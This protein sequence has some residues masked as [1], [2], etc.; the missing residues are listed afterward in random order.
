MRQL[1]ADEKVVR[2]AYFLAVRLD[3]IL[4]QAG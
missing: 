2:R 3:T 4:Q 1:E